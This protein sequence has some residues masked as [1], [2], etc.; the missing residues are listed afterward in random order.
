MS[1][2]NIYIF[3]KCPIVMVMP[4]GACIFKAL[5]QFFWNNGQSNSVQSSSFILALL[6]E[7]PQ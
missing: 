2:Y 5:R 7:N 6:L 3:G 1:V 4:P